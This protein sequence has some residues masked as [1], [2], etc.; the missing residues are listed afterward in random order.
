M[1]LNHKQILAYNKL[2]DYINNR[3]E[4]PIMDKEK[5]VIRQMPSEVERQFLDALRIIIQCGY[6]LERKDFLDI[7]EFI[8]I[9]EYR[10]HISH[11]QVKKFFRVASSELGFEQSL[12]DIV[13]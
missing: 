3:V 7:L 11:D 5:A 13:L 4:K 1:N 2:L 8:N 10:D 6:V 9:H 12:I